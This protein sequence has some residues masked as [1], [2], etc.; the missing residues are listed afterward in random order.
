MWYIG[1]PR[2]E[3]RFRAWD[4]PLE[5]ARFLARLAHFA[6]AFVRPQAPARLALKRGPKR[7]SSGLVGQGSR[8]V[9]MVRVIRGPDEAPAR[10]ALSHP[11]R[12]GHERPGGPTEPP[13]SYSYSKNTEPRLV[14]GLD[15][16]RASIVAAGDVAALPVFGMRLPTTTGKRGER[17]DS[18]AARGAQAHPPGRTSEEAVARPQA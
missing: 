1:G 17:D 7:V 13:G 16:E 6:G 3:T 9:R 15:V 5:T 4:A 18:P 12:H 2:H 10:G 11:R 8:V 14:K